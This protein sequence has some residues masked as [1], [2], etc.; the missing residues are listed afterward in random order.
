ME[1][2]IW[3]DE[4]WTYETY[5][6]KTFAVSAGTPHSIEMRYCCYCGGHLVEEIDEIEG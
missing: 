6:G 1:A 5:C 4:G 2:C 3:T